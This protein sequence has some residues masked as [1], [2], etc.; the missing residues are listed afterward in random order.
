MLYL[1]LAVIAGAS[2]G[3]CGKKISGYVNSISD[4]IVMNIIRMFI[5]CLIGVIFAAVQRA[6][7]AVSGKE[8]AIYIF[9]GVSMAAFL[10]SWLIA[11]KSGAYM[12]INAFTTASFTVTM[13]F[14]FMV[15]RERISVKQIISMFFIIAAIMFLMKYSSKIKAKITVKD[16]MLLMVVLI[17]SG[18][19]NVAQKMFTAW[20]PGGNKVIFNFYTFLITL[21]AL[22]ISMPII[23]SNAPKANFNYKKVVPYIAV[24]AVMLFA[25]SY[26]LTAATTVMSSVIL[27]PLNHVL[28]L[29]AATLM[30]AIFFK[31]KI[32]RTSAAGIICTVISI[33]LT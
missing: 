11:V 29:T 15:F 8:L 1:I 25:N 5:C 27:F 3:F 6:S 16:F 26:F 13:V 7:F 10:I 19:T 31:E 22:C 18:F 4:S 32:T 21:A 12:L 33:L 28:S 30:A 23:S 17:S 2:K 20:I 24:M 9:S 14:G